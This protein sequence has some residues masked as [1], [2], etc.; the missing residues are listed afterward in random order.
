MMIPL[1]Y[2]KTDNGKVLL[3][4]AHPM[5]FIPVMVFPSWEEFS[6]FRDATNTFHENN[7]IL[8]DKQKKISDD[9]LNNAF[10]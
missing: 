10:N 8:N 2:E 6:Q 4:A 3:F 1:G 5:G 9:I 7:A